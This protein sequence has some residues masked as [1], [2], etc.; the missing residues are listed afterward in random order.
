MMGMYDYV[1]CEVDLP[2][3]GDVDDEFQTKDFGCQMAYFTIRK[4]GR[5]IE[6][7]F[8]Y[9]DVPI[10]DR[11]N[12]EQPA[13]GCIKKVVDGNGDKNYHGTLRFYTGSPWREY[14]AKFTDG[15]LVG[16]AKVEPP[17]DSDV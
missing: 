3:G 13:L 9:E 10:E 15:Q 17:E 5:L 6:E 2:D 7:F 14:S 1:I 16:I 12:P 8:H 11:P 4:D